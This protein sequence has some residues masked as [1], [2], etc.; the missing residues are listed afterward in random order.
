M[1]VLRLAVLGP[2]E[3]F[4]DS[5]RLSFALRKAQALLLYL[6]V[7]GGMHSRSKLAALLWPDSES[8]DA[9]RTLR[10]ALGL[11]RSL[12]A[13]PNPSTAPASLSPRQ[14]AHLLSQGDLIGLNPRAPLEL[15]L[16]V[17]QQ[18]YTVA[19]R[20]STPPSEPQRDA[21]VSQVQQALTLIR[22]PF[23]DGFWLREE[24]AFDTWH[25]QQEQQWQVRLQL[26]FERLSAWQEAGGELEQARATLTRWLALDPLSEEAYQCLMRVHL[27]RGDA[28]AALQVYATCRVRLAEELQVKPSPETVALAERIRATAAARDGSTPA[29]RVMASVESQ[30]PGELVA[31]LIGRA[32]AFSH[33]VASFQQVRGGQAQGVLVVGEAGIG[34]T[35][36]AHEFVAWAQAQGAEVL[37]GHTFE[38]GGRLPYQPLVEALRERLEAENA[39]EDLL[40]DVWLA[41]LSRLLPELRGRYPDLPAPTQDELTARGQLFEAVARLLDALAQRAPLV[42][43]VDDL[44]WADG[45]SL[46]L[47]RYLGRH[48]KGHG[49]RVLLLLTLR[50]EELELT[51]RLSTQLADLGRDLPLRQV[52]LQPLSQAQT[53]QLIETLVGERS[54]PGAARPTSAGSE[55]ALASERP[56]LTLGDFLFA[57]TGGQPLYLLETLK[58]LRER[59]WLVPQ[60]GPDGSWRLEPSRE[61]TAALAQEHTRRA[62]LPSSVRAMILARLAKLAPPARQLLM[63]SAVLG[64]QASARLLWQLTE[65]NTQAGLEALEEA[66]KSGLLREEQ[67][68]GP[69]TGRPGRYRFAHNLILE[70]VYTELGEARRQVLHQRALE[71]LASEGAR[72]SELAYHALLAGEDESAA[73]YS[74]QAGDEALAV[75]AVEEA[76]GHYQQARALLQE[77]KR[78]QTE[79]AAAEVERLYTHLGQ[80][81]TFQNAWEKAQEA[82]EELLA[83]AQHQRQFTLASMALNRLA[84]LVAQQANDKPQAQA[85]LEDAWRMAET[86][87]DQKAL[88]ETAWNRFQITA[89]VWEDPE[90]AFPHGEQALSLARARHD[91]ELEARCLF[92]LGVIHLLRGDVEETMH[93]AQASLALYAALGHEAT[94]SGELS[95]PSFAIGAPLTQPLTY[96]ATEALC[97]ALL[98]FAQVYAGQLP[99]IHSGRRALALSKESK[100]VWDQVSST[101]YLAYGL[102]EAGAYEEALVLTLHAMALARTLPPTINFQGLLITLGS[103]YQALQQWQEAR[104]TLEE[105]E[106]MAETLDPRQ[107]RV[108]ALSQLCMHYAEAGEWEQAYRY[109][110]KAIA[111]RRS[112]DVALI[113]LDFCCQYET[114][115]LLRGGD[116][117][118][119]REAVHQLRERLGPYRRFRIPYL[120]SLAV[121]AAWEGNTE[122]AIDHLREAAGLAADLGLPAE[123]WQIQERLGR[124]YQASGEQEQARTAF[125]EAARIIQG[126]AEGIGDEAL[127]TN[128]LAG[129]R[130]QPLLQPG[131]STLPS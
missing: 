59:E 61:M 34:K 85:L 91:Q 46:D 131:S 5:R 37:S 101:T 42:L 58:L 99:S 7:Q 117:R 86:S 52:S 95:L 9:R 113:L 108:P 98:A 39:P 3:I 66:V 115:A 18:A 54:E 44:Q 71:R 26:L 24:T 82:Y 77:P 47:L 31:P 127:R 111:A 16:E 13:D 40:E 109:A 83:Y 90:R 48:W 49:S 57:Q 38:A 4:H 36:L 92:T 130:I 23:L 45:A 10:N 94:A 35:R 20:F 121:L 2:P 69:G 116:E 64:S 62:L 32:A 14:E 75:F 33:L 103:T 105:A 89:F 78:I 19:Q 65:L 60:L 112:S 67:A 74:V 56:L 106:A 80:A 6:A 87:S 110:L 124:L 41:E 119:A 79:L 70:V 51:P 22:G 123:Q 53:L 43:L 88:A 100:S 11:L 107:L 73:R 30:P 96:R 128:F 1:S 114:E 118:Q 17:V 72:T 120:R 21:L 93:Y 126:L 27:A 8:F 97:W 81:Y 15:D 84:I 25:E 28:N 63:A 55:P 76:I 129:P 122:Q 68:G 12:L 29:R 50:R 104:S 102:L 125:G